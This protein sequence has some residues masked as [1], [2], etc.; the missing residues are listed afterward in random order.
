MTVKELIK[1]LEFCQDNAPVY[2]ATPDKSDDYFLDAVRIE[3]DK[4]DEGTVIFLVT[5]Q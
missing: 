3:S 2:V 1:C 4:R 5:S